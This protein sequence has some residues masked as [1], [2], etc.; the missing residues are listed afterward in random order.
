MDLAT[1]ESAL[2]KAWTKDTCYPP[3]ATEWTSER[4]A[5]GQC[6]VTALIVQDYLGGDIIQL[7][8]FDGKGHFWNRINGKDIDLTASQF[9]QGDLSEEKVDLSTAKV[10]SRA[11]LDAKESYSQYN[12]RYKILKERVKALLS[13]N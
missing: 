1:L 12:Y 7:S 10:V 9:D 6:Y 5:F 11:E 2:R 3:I 13:V 4:P 8:F